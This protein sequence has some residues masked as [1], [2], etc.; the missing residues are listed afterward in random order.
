MKNLKIMLFISSLAVG[1][2]VSAE[3]K[4]IRFLN[5]LIIIS[6][7]IKFVIFHKWSVGEMNITSVFG[8]K[9]FIQNIIVYIRF[10]LKKISASLVQVSIQ[11]FSASFSASLF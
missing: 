9:R 4:E 3:D 7:I 8:S 10:L 11:K 1:I 5:F 6:F 2:S